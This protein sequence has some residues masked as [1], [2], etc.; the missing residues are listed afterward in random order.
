MAANMGQDPPFAACHAVINTTELLEKILL[1]MDGDLEG[2]TTILFSQRVSHAFKNIIRGSKTLRKELILE[3]PPKS[4]TVP[5]S[6][7][8]QSEKPE[9]PA[10]PIPQLNPLLSQSSNSSQAPVLSNPDQSSPQSNPC[11][12]PM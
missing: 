10:D 9:K 8:P 4:K 2:I 11:T 12:F 3:D 6:S 7:T 1:S 5:S